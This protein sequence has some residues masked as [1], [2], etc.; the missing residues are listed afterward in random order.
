MKTTFKSLFVLKLPPGTGD[1]I[2]F[3][4]DISSF[5]L[6]IREGGSKTLSFHSK[7]GSMQRKMALGKLVKVKT[8]HTFKAAAKDYL[9]HERSTLRSQ[10]YRDVDSHLLV[11][12]KALH[13]LRCTFVTSAANT[14]VIEAALNRVASSEAA[15]AGTY[16][17]VTY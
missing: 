1:Y 2:E 16:N 11:P 13:D 14:Y 8:H 4:D 6:R 5:G 12:V 9:E 15:V 7:L 10:L 3:D 17:R